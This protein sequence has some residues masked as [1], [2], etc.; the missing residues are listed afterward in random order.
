MVA[1]P[2]ELPYLESRALSAA[3]LAADQ[4]TSRRADRPLDSIAWLP[5]QHRVLSCPDRFRL[6]RG[7]N[8]AIGK[9][10]T[11]LAEVLFA[12]TGEH[13]YR[14][15]SREH[16]EYW[17]ICA[18]WSQS[19]AIQSKLYELA[20]KDLLHP[21]TIFNPGRGFP[22][23][24]PYVRIRHVDGGYSIIRIK[25]TRQGT[26]QLAGASIDGALF[27]EPPTSHAVYG[28]IVKRVQA[29]GGWVLLCLTPI[30]A[31]VDWLR[32]LAE[33]GQITD[34]HQPLTP[35][36]LIPVGHASPLVLADGT[37]CDQE[38]IDRITRETPAHE[39]PVRIGGEWETRMTS[40]YFAESFRWNE[41][42]SDDAPDADVDLV[43]GIDHG[44]L[45]GKQIAL[46]LAIWQADGRWCVHVL[47]EYVDH[48]GRATSDDDARGIL[49][50]LDRHGFVWKDL[51]GAWG[52]RVHMRGKAQQKSNLDLAGALCH[53]MR[54]R[55]MAELRPSIWTV[56]RGAG[57]GAGSVQVGCRWLHE[58]MV[59][60]RFT[61]SR[62]CVR[63][64][65]AIQRY[66]MRYQDDYADPIDALRYGLDT[67]IFAPRI[68]QG[69]AARV[70]SW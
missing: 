16:G 27:D 55:T 28:E 11:G 14:E 1:D 51:K 46:L 68:G 44:T 29:R 56:K 65:E 13:P 19:I 8:Q 67:L 31:P 32:Q 17:V 53:L 18:S 66:Q 52:D 15:P 70:R 22:G 58:A 43:L 6:Y 34:I 54:I 64:I 24:Y 21:G 48:T 60:R 41:H 30:G 61:V 63:L 45:P 35:E 12:A 59:Q 39:V 20:P 3:V 47:D 50:M 25:T 7:P 42:I 9:T 37:V 57:H 62:R 69:I 2:S 49:D 4:A 5:S 23:M 36:A 10:W 26:L 33:D 38:W 40:S